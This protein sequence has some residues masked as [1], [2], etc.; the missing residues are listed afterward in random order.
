VPT[1]SGALPKALAV[2]ELL[3]ANARLSG[4][5]IARRI[6]VD[7]RAV[8]RHIAQLEAMG[9]PITSERGPHGGYGLTPGFKLT[10]M[11]FGGDE[12]LALAVGLRAVRSLGLPGLAPAV[13]S[14]QA[15]LERVLA[16]QTQSQVRAI[17]TAVALE[18]GS[19]A[20]SGTATAGISAVLQVL[21]AAVH[22]RQRVQLSY[23]AAQ[24]ELSE[25]AFDAYGI[26][27]RGGVWYCVG[28]CHLRKELRS[29]RLDRIRQVVALPASFAVPQG[30]DALA[31]LEDRLAQLPRAHAI[32]VLLL[33]DLPTASLQLFNGLGLLQPESEGVLL[34]AQADD[35]DW[36]AREL[37][38]LPF[39]FRVLK[40]QALAAAVR[41]NANRL[42]AQVENAGEIEDAAAQ[43]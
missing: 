21:A 15:K 17:D 16:P 41:G 40:P 3:Q 25:R 13:A 43:A 32:E 14:A 20:S 6:G 7:A 42:L 26:A 12:T 35:L 30:F 37:S 23:A 18:L 5:E 34:K 19:G 8:R 29:L 39:G 11:L 38:R 22:L 36:F 27:Y 1:V 28:A 24:G 2:L 10:P 9:F 33:T 4:S 31:Y